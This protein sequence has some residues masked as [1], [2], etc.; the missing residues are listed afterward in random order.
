MSKMASRLSEK[1]R[2]RVTYPSSGWQRL[3]KLDYE[4][5]HSILAWTRQIFNCGE[6]VASAAT[7]RHFLS[8]QTH[9]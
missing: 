1:H 8:N 9:F 2:R 6:V 7:A 3:G 5:A 4:K